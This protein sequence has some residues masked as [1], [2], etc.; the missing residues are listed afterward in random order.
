MAVC[1]K[2]T[3]GHIHD[4][5]CDAEAANGRSSTVIAIR[6]DDEKVLK[7]RELIDA[8]EIG[9]ESVGDFIKWLIDTQGL[10]KR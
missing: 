2:A 3:A 9:Y 7:M 4:E 1:M 5:V 6:V 10:R 8:S